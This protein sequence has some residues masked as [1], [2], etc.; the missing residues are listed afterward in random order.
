MKTKTLFIALA[1]VLLS[2]CA[3]YTVEMRQFKPESHTED[4]YGP[5]CPKP[6][7]VAT[8]AIKA[9]INKESL[10]ISQDMLTLANLLDTAQRKYGA[11]VTIQNIRWDLKSGD[12]VSAVFD[13]IKCKN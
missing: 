13:V 3:S 9:T 2:S 4:L 7:Y 8:M 6:T 10:Q 5:A 1:V 11:E 12:K